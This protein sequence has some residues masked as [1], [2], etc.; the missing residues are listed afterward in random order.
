MSGLSD[1][2]VRVLVTGFGPFPSMPYNASTSVALALGD[3][4]DTPGVDIA[5]AVIPVVWATARVV[6]RKAVA[7]FQPHA[8]L[9]FGVS[10]RSSGFEI[11]T[12]AFNMSGRKEDQA[13]MVRR[14]NALVRA[15]KPVLNAT[16]P[17]LD[18]VRTL[19]K[20]GFPAAL[21]EDPGRYLCN[22]LFY[23]SLHDGESDGRL[24]SFVHMPA[25]DAEMEVEPRLTMEEAVAGARILIRASAEAVL[26]A[27]E[28]VLKRGGSIGYGSQALYRDGRSG[29]LAGG[30][31]G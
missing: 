8:I 1:Q 26:R 11:E 13:G 21:S 30:S 12:R 16:L 7:R 5:T 10:K 9:H 27:R 15:G 3:A 17:P 19:R 2:S 18:L 14:A 23:W 22:A 20:D 31:D 28:D 6:A 25:L 24:V 29:R 4:P